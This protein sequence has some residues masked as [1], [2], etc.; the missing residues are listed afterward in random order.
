MVGELWKLGKHFSSRY[1]CSLTEKF[2]GELDQ[3]KAV[4]E[5]ITS[6]SQIPKD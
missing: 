1:T 2:F 5:N 6:S 4:G 3:E